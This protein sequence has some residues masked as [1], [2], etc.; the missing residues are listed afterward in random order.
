[1]AL[2][3]NAP[4]TVILTALILSMPM[5]FPPFVET[6]LPPMY[7]LPA[8]PAP[9]LTTTAPV[10]VDVAAL[11]LFITTFCP[12]TPYTLL[13]NV[14]TVADSLVLIF[15]PNIL[16]LLTS[17]STVA[18]PVL[19]KLTPTTL[20]LLLIELTNAAVLI[21]SVSPFIL[22]LLDSCDA[23]TMPLATRLAPLP[24]NRVLL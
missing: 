22:L 1:M 3:V 5:I 6:I 10:V 11:V 15:V 2:V 14:L 8:M 4:E 21:A 24:S 18:V 12:K 7:R 13:S 23:M 16:V 19:C 17:A 20:V 9:P